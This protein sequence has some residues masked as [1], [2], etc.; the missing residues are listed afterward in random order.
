VEEGKAALDGGEGVSANGTSALPSGAQEQGELIAD[1]TLTGLLAEDTEMAVLA[2]HRE[3]GDVED[4]N[5]DGTGTP[6]EHAQ[7]T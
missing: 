7:E 5:E 1:G 4:A 3:N 6:S 2:L